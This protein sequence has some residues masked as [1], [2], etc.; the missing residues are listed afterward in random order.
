[1]A[2]ITDVGAAL[3][4]L[5]ALAVYP[6][7]ITQ[8]S[9]SGTGIR[10][11]QGWPN[12]QQLDADIRVGICHVSVYPTMTETNKTRY[13]KDWQQQGAG[14]MVREIRRQ[15]RVFQITV[16]AATPALRD[17]VAAAVDVTLTGTEF[18]TM[19]DGFGARIIYRNS[20]ISDDLQKDKLY[21]RD[22][23]YSVEY[24]TTQTMAA[25]AI[26]QTITNITLTGN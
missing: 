12:P 9:V 7:G 26:T 25:T 17:V 24:A 16:W 14:M 1:M 8:P 10:V 21:R 18:L 11:Y 6:N 13:P 5:A 15:D 22:F 20:H 3:V 2:D 4:A 19:P 23:Q